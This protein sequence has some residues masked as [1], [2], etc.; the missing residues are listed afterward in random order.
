[1]EYVSVEEQAALLCGDRDFRTSSSR[2]RASFK[3]SV[4][5]A[6]WHGGGSE[7]EVPS[8]E[9]GLVVGESVKFRFQLFGEKDKPGD[10][11]TQWGENELE[12]TDSLES[13]LP[14]DERLWK[15]MY[16]CT[17]FPK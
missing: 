8:D 14:A 10:L 11:L 4:C 3:C 13:K 6:I 9:I 12:E 15:D 16:Q 1:M 2:N 5:S 17:F 7:I